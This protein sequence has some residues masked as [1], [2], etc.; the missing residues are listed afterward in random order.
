MGRHDVL[1]PSKTS[2]R[3]ED[4]RPSARV[5]ASAG[6]PVL[7]L[8]RWIGNRAVQRWIS[9]AHPHPQA[10]I[11]ASGRRLQRVVADVDR[12][13]GTGVRTPVDAI[14][15]NSGPAVRLASRDVPRVARTAAVNSK[16]VGTRRLPVVER[17]VQRD[18]LDDFTDGLASLGETVAQGTEAVASAVAS[19]AETVGAAV[20]SGVDAASEAASSGA[21]AIGSAVTTGAQAVASGVGS[22]V[23]AVEEVVDSSAQ[24]AAAIVDLATQEVEP[25]ID[26]LLDWRQIQV[27]WDSEP[28]RLVR[29]WAARLDPAIVGRVRDIS[30]SE[31]LSV[32]SV[33]ADIQAAAN[34]LARQSR[35]DFEPGLR[36][37][38]RP[39]FD[40]RLLPG[41][42]PVVPP[43]VAP[44]LP[45]PI[46]LVII[47]VLAI[48][49]T[50][51]NTFDEKGFED[52]ELEKGKKED[53]Q[54]RAREKKKENEE[55]QGRCRETIPALR[56]QIHARTL[57]DLDRNADDFIN[58]RFKGENTADELGFFFNKEQFNFFLSITGRTKNTVL[59][60]CSVPNDTLATSSGNKRIADRLHAEEL[61]APLLIAQLQSVPLAEREGATLFNVC[62]SRACVKE[63]ASNPDGCTAVL[64]GIRDRL[65][66]GGQVVDEPTGFPPAAV[67]I[68]A[69]S[70][71]LLRRLQRRL[72]R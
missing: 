5:P 44:R 35:A 3:E 4:A 63:V 47:I 39:G 36:P 30:P 38:L 21:K 19:G 56:A 25:V 28:G 17:S 64:E 20:E 53:E 55:E 27:N 42:P 43:G 6:H 57:E 12:G 18:L 14:A 15:T 33:P 41:R 60:V 72:P 65:L 49:L 54:R 61:A 23:K 58:E 16:G 68:P 50:P 48:L 52:K 37:G 7:D 34:E 67:L 9:A 32:V 59:K 46:I 8:Q 66:P 69:S 24:Q 51:T 2:S 1:T 22:G 13:A 70:A 31:L 71:A 45:P 62:Q 26:S 10:P 29:A 11:T 40:P